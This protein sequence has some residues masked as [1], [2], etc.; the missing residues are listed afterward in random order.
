MTP[1]NDEFEPEPLTGVAKD[2]VLKG[3]SSKDTVGPEG[4]FLDTKNA[5]WSGPPSMYPSLSSPGM[6]TSSFFVCQ[7]VVICFG[8]NHVFTNSLLFSNSYG[9]LKQVFFNT[10]CQV[11]VGYT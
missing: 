7:L 9:L 8:A 4:I 1:I 6:A 5:G 2:E 11:A 3:S 10:T